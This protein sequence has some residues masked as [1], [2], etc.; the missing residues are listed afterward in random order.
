MIASGQFKQGGGRSVLQLWD[1]QT[2]QVL[3]H[4]TGGLGAVTSISFSPEGRRFVCTRTHTATM[5]WR[6]D[7][8]NTTPLT[9]EHDDLDPPSQWRAERFVLAGV[10]SPDGRWLATAYGSG[11]IR[12]WRAEDRS[13]VHELSGHTGDCRDLAFSTDSSLLASASDDATAR[14][15][16]VAT[17][18]C[19]AVLRGHGDI[20]YAVAFTP[21]RTRLATGS[22]DASIRLW[23]VA[24][25][26][27]LL[28]LR[29]HAD[30]VYTL[31][32]SPDGTQLATGSGDNTI[33]LW[34]TQ[35]PHEK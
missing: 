15:W 2:G 24:S 31:A 23:E 35:P 11:L 13:L 26:K 22:R 18:R 4:L 9:L 34:N 12:I 19:L 17:G 33:R 3:H 10:W 14:L 25:G 29:G 1:A 5:I 7:E 27:E 32:F 6:T 8:V 30:Y 21:D 20:V 28:Q 16:D